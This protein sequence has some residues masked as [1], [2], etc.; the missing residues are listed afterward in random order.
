M[1][2][3]S[4]FLFYTLIFLLSIFAT[5]SETAEV[6]IVAKINNNIITNFDLVNEK[7]YLLALNKNFQNLDKKTI[8]NISKESVIRENIKKIELKKYYELGNINE[9]F[10][11]SIRQIY[12]NLGL[13]DLENFKNYLKTE[14][15][16]FEDVY[17]KIEIE[18]L[19]NQLIY[20]KYNQKLIINEKDL[21]AE[22]LKNKKKQKQIKFSE[23]LFSFEKKEEIMIKY[24][25]IVNDLKTE[26]F[27]EIVP[28]YSISDSVKNSGSLDWVNENILSNRIKSKIKDLKI[29]DISQPIIIPS[30]ALVLKIDDIRIIEKKIDLEKELKKSIEY[31]I[32]NQLNNYSLIYYNKIKNNLII[33]EL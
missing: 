18:T 9:I 19:W 2:K 21:E 20:T 13:K 5:S 30:G 15:L 24:K 32:N 11:N 10:D 1:Y 12:I 23:I 14:D 26:N 6:K 28:K 27:S 29:N 17:K 33:N 22:I 3:R 31:E 4:Y 8:E 16:E 25:K 7:K